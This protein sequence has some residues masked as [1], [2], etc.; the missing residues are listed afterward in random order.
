MPSLLTSFLSLKDTVTSVTSL[1][2]RS[3]QG[4]MQ[5]RLSPLD[6]AKYSDTTHCTVQTWFQGQ[7]WVCI[8]VRVRIVVKHL[9]FIVKFRVRGWEMHHVNEYPHYLLTN[10]L[11][12]LQICLCV[13]VCVHVCECHFRI[14]I[15]ESQQFYSVLLSALSVGNNPIVLTSFKKQY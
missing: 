9:F 11:F 10:S 13:C 5:Y 4:S 8:E 1:K 7:D 6:P 12:P 14:T 2:G 3:E 15:L